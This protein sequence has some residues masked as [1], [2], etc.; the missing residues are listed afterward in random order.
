[1]EEE[2]EI[3]C[4]QVTPKPSTEVRGTAD[5]VWRPPGAVA[6]SA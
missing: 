1:M 4:R 3:G 5:E 6:A 2:E